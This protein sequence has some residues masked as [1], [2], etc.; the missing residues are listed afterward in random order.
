METVINPGKKQT[1]KIVNY[2]GANNA[3]L[4]ALA[5]VKELKLGDDVAGRIP[6]PSDNQTTVNIIQV[7]EAKPDTTENSSVT[8]AIKTKSG[9]ST[10]A[11]TG[12][13]A[14]ACLGTGGLGAAIP[15]AAGF[16]SQKSDTTVV[17][18]PESPKINPNF[19]FDVK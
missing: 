2:Q 6:Y 11:K 9:L 7:P 5:L 1:D 17:S 4:N 8:G 12:L 18:S 14:A 3:Y 15:I 19:S 13:V 16:L 10:L